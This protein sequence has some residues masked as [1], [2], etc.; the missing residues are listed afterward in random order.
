MAKKNASKT[1]KT[2]RGKRSSQKTQ[3]VGVKKKV[4]VPLVKPTKGPGIG[5]DTQPKPPQPQLNVQRLT[6]RQKAALAS[7][8]IEQQAKDS[9]MHE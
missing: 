6:K 1:K 8:A 5:K 2:M 9:E 7:A 3:Q 4:K